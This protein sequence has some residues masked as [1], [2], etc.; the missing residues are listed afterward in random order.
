[1][2]DLQQ[3]FNQQYL[4]EK[5]QY[6]YV[7]VIYETTSLKRPDAQTGLARYIL[8]GRLCFVTGEV[9][10]AAGATDVV[11]NESVGITLPLPYG[12]GVADTTAMDILNDAGGPIK[13]SGSTLILGLA[14]T[15][16]GLDTIILTVGNSDAASTDILS[17]ITNST[18][19]NGFINFFDSG[20]LKFSGVFP[21]DVQV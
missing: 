18:T 2:A 13:F 19:P 8:S 9:S 20:T 21:I 11:G 4:N 10:W 3:S 1:M 6:T 14:Q 16:G 17:Y 15:T 7:P 12:S 5:V